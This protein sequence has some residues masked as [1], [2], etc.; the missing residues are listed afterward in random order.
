V[1]LR[2]EQIKLVLFVKAAAVQRTAGTTYEVGTLSAVLARKVLGYEALPEWTD[3]PTDGNL[4]ESEVRIPYSGTS[5]LCLLKVTAGEARPRCRSPVNVEPA[6]TL[7]QR[8]HTAHA[9]F[10]IQ[11]FRPPHGR[12][13]GHFTGRIDTHCRSE[14]VSG[15][16]RFPQLGER[17][18]G[19]DGFGR[20]TCNVS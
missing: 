19:G 10:R 4:R 7:Q 12:V 9:S 1:I 2:R 16:G 13:I 20:G 8:L 5:T 15:P 17:V 14:Q 11:H 6:Y 18:G 3:D